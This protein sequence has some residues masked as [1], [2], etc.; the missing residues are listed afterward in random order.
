MRTQQNFCL[1][2]PVLTLKNEGCLENPVLTL[3]FLENPVLTLKN[4]GQ[5]GGFFL[6]KKTL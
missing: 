1:E 6:T 5:D 4:E 2:N 3:I